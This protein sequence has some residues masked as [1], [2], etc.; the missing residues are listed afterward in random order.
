MS[1]LRDIDTLL[2]EKVLQFKLPV[3]HSVHILAG[4][5]QWFTPHPPSRACCHI[6]LRRGERSS[7]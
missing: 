7:G 2:I 5:A 3:V 6:R 4:E 1:H